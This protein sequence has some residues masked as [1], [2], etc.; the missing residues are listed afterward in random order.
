[1]V[2][3]VI[4]LA[5]YAIPVLDPDRPTWLLDLCRRYGGN[6]VPRT[7]ERLPPPYLSTMSAP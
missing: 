1:M 6:G 7:A 5:A 3:A 4:F 2:A